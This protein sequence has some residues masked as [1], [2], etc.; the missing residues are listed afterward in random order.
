M[1]FKLL[2][3]ALQ[4]TTYY[5]TQQPYIVTEDEQV[6][7]L[8]LFVQYGGNTRWEAAYKLMQSNLLA[9]KWKS[10]GYVTLNDHATYHREMHTNIARAALQIGV[11]VPNKPQQVLAFF[12]SIDSGHPDMAAHILTI[13][14][15][16]NGL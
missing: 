9:R 15:D 11:T 13:K 3:N 6:V 1:S 2:D 12:V 14:S 7:S 4:G 8:A 10:T 16:A 5:S